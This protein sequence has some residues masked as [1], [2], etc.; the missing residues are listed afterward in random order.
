MVVRVLAPAALVALA[1]N[2]VGDL[3]AQAFM[4]APYPHG[5]AKF[6]LESS[7]GVLYRQ[8]LLAPLLLGAAVVVPTLSLLRGRAWLVAAAAV[9]GGSLL[10][11]RFGN[12]A[13]V[14][15][16]ALTLLAGA[17]VSA[18]AAWRRAASVVAWIPGSTALA[19][20][21]VGA[22]VGT[23]AW[24]GAH[25]A[26][27]AVVGAALALAWVEVDCLT[28]YPAVRAAME[29]WPDHLLD[30]ELTV[31]AHSEPGVRADWHGV[32][33]V[34][35]HALVVAETTTR[36]LAFPLDGG[37]PTV[38]PLAE[39]WGPHSVA[40]LDSETDPTTGRTWILDKERD[41]VELDFADGRLVERRR[42]QLPVAPGYA[43]L[44]R[45][46]DE[47]L[48]TSVQI[49]GPTPRRLF[50]VP[51]PSLAPARVIELHAKGER[52]GQHHPGGPGGAP[53]PPPGGPGPTGPIGP[54]AAP[55]SGL[56]AAASPRGGPDRDAPPGGL[57]MPREVE[58][59]PTL[60]RLVLAPDFDDHLW[61]ADP[62][63]GEAERWVEMPTLDGKMRY[64]PRLDR[65]VVALPNRLELWVLDP[66]TGAVDWT[67][68]TQPGV[69][70]L[71]LDDRRGLVVSASVVTGQIWVQDVRTGAVRKRLGTVMPM[72]REL[73][74]SEE[75]GE[76]VLTTWVAT[77]QFP[78]VDP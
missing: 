3:V 4:A 38:F 25:Q 32:Q 37:E 23:L 12:T 1:P 44:R 43:Y 2:L 63:T 40:P 77:Y 73:S 70:S 31:L 20:S 5:T 71:A 16:L 50:R 39:R 33:V 41:L 10:L 66:A 17:P 15:W 74:L 8:P 11:P 35:D 65:L 27:V 7:Q 22:A 59:L 54:T 13:L 19:P 78:Y 58:W 76:G 29:R 14:P 53:P 69:R 51:L 21:V 52:P 64:S 49:A 46:S 47:L 36:L 68:P 62:R 6:V 26:L 48:L 60:K 9:V 42:V 45:T 55:P 18:L 24:R 28:S 30:D 34:G 61:L 75:R 57:P 56:S 72:V 67:V